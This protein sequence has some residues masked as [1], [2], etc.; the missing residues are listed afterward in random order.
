MSTA[1]DKSALLP[2]GI[3]YKLFDQ[4][5]QGHEENAQAI[6]ELA[7]AV[8]NLANTITTPPMNK[9][10]IDVINR[11]D[12][13]VKDIHKTTIDTIQNHDQRDET[14]VSGLYDNL[15]DVAS[16]DDCDEM[17]TLLE[18][19]DGKLTKLSSRVITMIMIVLIT[20]SLMTVS[21]LFV[22]HSINQTVQDCVEEHIEKSI[23]VLK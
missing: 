1:D 5:K 17:K 6:K 3:V 23:K 19:V 4:S 2:E 20:F 10:V 22:R 16:D 11:H 21:Y 7:G 12:G 18:K 8:G 15:K 9:D 13:D 14:R